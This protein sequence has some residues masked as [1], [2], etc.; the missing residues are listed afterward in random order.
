MKMKNKK[1]KEEKLSPHKKNE[2]KNI[3]MIDQQ[4]LN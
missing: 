2:N 4:L 1:K 3:E